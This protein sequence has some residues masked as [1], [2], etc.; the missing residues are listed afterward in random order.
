MSWL[1]HK[2]YKNKK[3]IFKYKNIFKNNIYIAN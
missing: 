3:N 1:K 2:F